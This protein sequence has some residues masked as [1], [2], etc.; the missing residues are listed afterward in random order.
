MNPSMRPRESLY[1]RMLLASRSTM[2]QEVALDLFRD[3]G[4]EA[5]WIHPIKDKV[6]KQAK[7]YK[8]ICVGCLTYTGLEASYDVQDTCP[9]CYEEGKLGARYYT[10]AHNIGLGTSGIDRRVLS[11]LIYQ[12]TDGEDI[13]EYR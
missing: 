1:I 12:A 13:N 8:E 10:L 7:P 9:R 2:P 11:Q 5:Q 4:F 6:Y 3:L